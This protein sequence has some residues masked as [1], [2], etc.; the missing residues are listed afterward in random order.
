MIL[1]WFI[2]KGIIRRSTGGYSGK[3]IK[4][5]I[6]SIA[7]SIAVMILSSLVIEGFKNEISHKIF[8]FWGNIH[9]TD[10]R[11]TRNFDLRPIKNDQALKA[12]IS[13][14]GQLEY[15]MDGGDQMT[16]TK[17]GVRSISPYITCP[18]ILRTKEKELEGIV[19]KGIDEE[20]DQAVF[21]EYLL[22][23]KFPAVSDS[24]PP[25]QILISEQTS[26][27]MKLDIDDKV[28]IY[29]F[30]S[31]GQVK[32]QF[33]I[34]G[35][36]RT[37]LEEYDRK[38]AFIDLRVIQGL[39]DWEADQ[40]GGY[41][42]FIDDVDDAIP[43]ADYIYQEV[44]PSNLYAETIQEKHSNIF[45]WLEFQDINER[46][47]FLLMVIVAL[48]NMSTALLILILERSKMV[49]ILKSLGMP[50][51]DLRSVFIYNAL[52][53]LGLALIIGNLLGLLIAFVQSRTG[54]LKL[55]EESYYLSEVPVHFDLWALIYINVGTIIVTLLVMIIPTFL[56]TKIDPIDILRFD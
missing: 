32:R 1:P 47:I 55:D 13:D 21:A 17:G 3:I 19:L 29:I 11:I 25:R 53:I 5:A 38:F 15:S 27:R 14:I 42:I 35:I 22:E 39:L 12:E 28:I 48:I 30:K 50:D 44:I 18:G 46:V 23:G 20:Y 54:F 40:V 33:K 43:I 2:A 7:L 4:L 52:Y 10:S 8:G 6:A 34:S 37:G 41:E 31:G 26:K 51:F 9:I 16:E 49:G 36:Y 45:E 56:V 24:V